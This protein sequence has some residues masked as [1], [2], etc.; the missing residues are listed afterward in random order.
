[1]NIPARKSPALR[2]IEGRMALLRKKKEF[3]QHSLLQHSSFVDRKCV[4]QPEKDRWI[5]VLEESFMDLL[6]RDVFD[7]M[8]KH[9]LDYFDY[10]NEI[11]M[12]QNRDGLP[13]LGLHDTLKKKLP[14]VRK[15]VLPAGEYLSM[16]ARA[17]NYEKAFLVFDELF[18]EAAVRGLKT[19]G[20]GLFIDDMNRFFY[21]REDLHLT[22][23]VRV[24][25]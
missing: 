1:M 13:V 2:K 10:Q 19:D 5:Y 25:S 22:F 7:F 18:A 8:H 4:L 15:I 9:N 11:Y 12:V 24:E 23:Q 3:V 21:S 16:T 20:T 17:E 14:G 6:I